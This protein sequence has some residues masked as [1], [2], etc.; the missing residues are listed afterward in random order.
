MSIQLPTIFSFK[1][2]SL[3]W[4]HC[5]LLRPNL[6]LKIFPYSS[7]CQ[8]FFSVISPMLNNAGDPVENISTFIRFVRSISYVDSLVQSVLTSG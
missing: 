8:F 6:Y 5:C 2:A 7:H 1:R 3:I 4:T